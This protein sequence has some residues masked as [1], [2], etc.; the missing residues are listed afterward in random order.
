MPLRTRTPRSQQPVPATTLDA[1]HNDPRW[2]LATRIA[3]SA[4][5]SR[6][7][8]LREMLLYV[9]R[10]SIQSPDEPLREPEI[11]H[12]VLGRRA[13]F[14]PLDDNIVRVQMAHLRRKLDS[15]FS[16]EGRDEP[17]LL[18]I[19]LGSYRP[20]FS[21]RP[22]PQ[23]PESAS[24]DPGSEAAEPPAQTDHDTGT[25][26]PTAGAPASRSAL[27]ALAILFLVALSAAVGLGLSLYR[28]NRRLDALQFQ[29]SPW[30]TRPTVSAFWSTFFN[31]QHDTDLILGDDSLLLIEQLNHQYVSL[32]SYL[33][34]NY[35]T[36]THGTATQQAQSLIGSKGLGSISEFKLAS[37]IL[38][39][40]PADPK[41]HTYSARQYLP[42][43]LKQNNI[44]L[45]GGRVSNPWVGL[46]D[47]Q[48]S[49]DEK[50]QFVDMGISQVEGRSTVSKQPRQWVA[51]DVVGYCVIGYLPHQPGERAVLI[52]EGTSSEATEAAGDFLFNEDQLAAL[53][54]KMGRTSFPPFE[55]L[56]RIEQVKGTPFTATIEA[57]EPH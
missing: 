9:V 49:F 26:A 40:D 55:V 35:L 54:H 24:P 34:R 32:N 10:N 8:Q 33:S 39:K 12:R 20:V 56:L 57:F 15:Y 25:S 11:A 23:E 45:I 46:F 28:A 6:A 38:A 27:T 48:L 16:E 13:D 2:Q 42:S 41:L 1:T 52:L 44:I 31:S 30:R 29:L 17:H 18:T 53:L 3:A 37:M 43:L 14:N 21:P 5:F 51:S 22:L 47:E 36:S 7:A 19:A 4:C 50:T